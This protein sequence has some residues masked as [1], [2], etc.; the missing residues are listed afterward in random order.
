MRGTD[1]DAKPLRAL[2]ID[3]DP[4]ALLFMRDV[5]DRRGGMDVATAGDAETALRSLDGVDVVVTDVEMPGMTGLELLTRIRAARPDQ[6][7]VVVTAHPSL[8]Y[9]VEALRGQAAEFLRKPL[10]PA[11]L[12]RVVTDL[13]RTAREA[14][15]AARH[16]VLAVGA[17]PD[18]V[19]I[20]VG[21]LLSAHA[22]RGDEIAIVTLTRGAR[23]GT[24]ATR[25]DE[26]RAAARM[27]GARLFLEDGEDTRLP[28]ND[29]T[30]SA[31]QRV[32]EEVRPQ[33]VYVHSFHDLHQDHRAVHQATMVAARKVPTI[34]CYQSP[35]ATVDF[36]PNRFVGIDD[37]VERKLDLLACFGSQVKTRDYLESEVIV[38]TARYWSRYGGGRYTE[39]LEVVRDRT[40]AMPVVEER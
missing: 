32:I 5:L 11:E 21:G 20:G 35:S 18:D 28:V 4:D 29:P 25:E 39:P 16:V 40:D 10:D 6:P 38:A 27:L 14:A 23:G 24:T 26:S 36:K 22:A 30:L 13:G 2:L 9:A 7:V 12:L 31:V 15:A 19:E 37:Y 3:D 34:A 17:H 33:T 1:G 8:D